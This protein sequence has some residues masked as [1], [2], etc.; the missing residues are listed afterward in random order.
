MEFYRQEYWS[1]LPLPP[2]G[3][4]PI[5]GSNLSL[6]HCKRIFFFTSEPPGKPKN[7]LTY[8]QRQL[9]SCDT[10]ETVWNPTD[11]LAFSYEMFSGEA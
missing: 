3:I 7:Y 5:Q 10:S 9:R 4:F 2:P 6:L 8:F 11:Y 1:G